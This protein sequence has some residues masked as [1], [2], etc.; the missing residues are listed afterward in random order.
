MAHGSS[1]RLDAATVTLVPLGLTAVAGYLAYRFARW[2][3]ASREVE[4]L[5]SLGS[6]AA[7]FAGAYAVV[8][9]LTALLAS[10]EAVSPSPARVFLG[11]LLLAGVAGGP[12]L[13]TGSRRWPQLRARLPESLLTVAAGAAATALMLVAAG[14]LLVGVALAADLAEAANVLSTLHVD[15]PG[16]LLYVVVVAA[17]GPNAALLGSAYLVGSGFAVGTATVVSPSAVALGPVPAFPLLAA[18]PAE[19]VPPW[20]AATG[21]C[22]P[23]LAGAAAVVLVLRR[24]GTTQYGSA[25]LQA[26]GIGL[27]GGG[28]LTALVALAGGSAG[29]GR[30]ADVGAPLGETLLLAVGAIAGG[31]LL[32]AM[33]S[34]WWLRRRE[35]RLPR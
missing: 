27:L 31:G 21:L 17:M 34:T 18:L 20:W 32:A 26:V 10:T 15:G 6:G 8:A 7:C 1:L 33:G 24:S 19:G 4:D 3:A 13:I 35:P 22:L 2:A 9:A 14:S 11:G 25:A 29:P 30:M 16:G 5:R 28:A 23:V 12:G